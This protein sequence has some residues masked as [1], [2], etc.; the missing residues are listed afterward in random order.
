[1]RADKTG[2]NSN[3]RESDANKYSLLQSE[4]KLFALNRNS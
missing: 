4:N 1:M 3:I 2:R